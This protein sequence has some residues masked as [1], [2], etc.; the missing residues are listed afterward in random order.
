MS[1]TYDIVLLGGT[2]VT[3]RAT[4]VHLS[5]YLP[6]GTKWA[7][8]GR[9]RERLEALTALG[10]EEDVKPDIVVVDLNDRGAVEKVIRETRVVLHLAGPYAEYGEQFFQLCIKHQTH[11]ADIGGETFFLQRM[12]QQYHGAA[13][14]AKVKIIPTAGY[15]SV[16]FDYLTYITALQVRER[17]KEGLNDVKIIASFLRTGGKRDN[18]ISGGSLG[19]MR[20]IIAGDTVGAFNDM[21]CLLPDDCDRK[22]VKRENRVRYAATLDPDVNAFVGPL[23][24]APFL[25]VPVILRSAYLHK[26]LGEP[27]GVSFKYRDAMTMEFYADSPAKQQ[28]A[29]NRSARLNKLMSI[30]MAA[31][32]FARGWLSSRLDNMNIDVGQGPDEATFPF[33]DYR[34]RLFGRTESGIKI[35]SEANAKGHPGYLSTSKIIA[36]VGM[37]LMDQE[38]DYQNFGIVTPSVGL[39]SAFTSQLE[40]AGVSFSSLLSQPET[41][42][43]ETLARA[44]S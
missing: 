20:S 18:R 11:Y 2:G 5:N 37:G 39:G 4:F 41:L 14:S 32:R 24:P 44:T 36:E 27:Y 16:P 15:E 25:N 35:T 29:A 3:G 43:S 23:Q 40:R 28:A 6:P 38:G 1:K 42:Q 8:A 22:A 17:F 10:S 34:L 26:Q 31:P 33:V 30:T 7:I 12:I 19:T 13:Q 9:N 21:S